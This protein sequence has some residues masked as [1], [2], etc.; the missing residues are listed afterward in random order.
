MYVCVYMCVY[1]YV[2]IFIYIL[3]MHAEGVWVYELTLSLLANIDRRYSF[4]NF[5]I[6]LLAN[7]DIDW[8]F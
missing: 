8:S 3:A 1:M 7:Y 4:W 2:Y 6:I 5:S